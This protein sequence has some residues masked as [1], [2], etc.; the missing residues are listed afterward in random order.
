MGPKQLAG[1]MSIV[2]R[3]AAERAGRAFDEEADAVARQAIE[4]Q[5]DGRV[6]RP[7]RHRSPLGRRHHRSARHAHRRSASRC[8]PCTAGRSRAPSPSACSDCDRSDHDRS[9]RSA[10]CSSPTGVRS[11]SGC[12][13]PPTSSVCAP[14]PSTPNRTAPQPM[15]TWPTWPCPSADRRRPTPISTRPSCS[16]PPSAQGADAVHPGYGFLSENADFA[17]AVVDAGLTWVG[18]H[19]EAIAVDGRQAGGQAAGRRRRHPHPAQRRVDRRRRARAGRVQADDVGYPLLIKAAAGRRRAG[20]AAR[21]RRGRA[22]RG[23]ALGPPRSGGLLRPP[24]RVRRALAGRRPD[25]VEVQVVADQLGNAIHLGERECSIQRRHQ[26]LIEECPSPAVDD[27]LRESLGAAALDAGPGHRLRQRRHR[28]VP[29]RSRERRQFYFLEMNTRIQVEHRVTEEVVGCDLVWWQ[30]QCARGEP[31][32]WIQDDVDLTDHP[33][34]RGP[35]LRRGPGS[36]LAARH[37]HDPPVRGSARPHF[38][39]DYVMV[40]SGMAVNVDGP[41]PVEV[42]PALRPAAGQVHRPR[43]HRETAIGRLVRYLI[44]LELHGVT[45]NRDYLLAVLQHPDFLDGRTTTLFVADHP[46]LLDAGPDADTVARHAAR[47]LVWRDT[48]AATTRTVLALRP[49]RAGATSGRPGWI[50]G[51]ATGTATSTSPAPGSS[52][53]RFAAE[54]DGVSVEGRLLERRPDH[55][56]LEIDGAT[57]CYWVS[58]SRSTPPMSTRALG[59]DR[60]GRAPDRFGEPASAGDRRRARRPRARPGRGRRGGGGR[61]GLGGPDTGRARVR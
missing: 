55:V 13:M 18:P 3:S 47:H 45:T 33:R 52:D 60:P 34:H 37:R 35:A 58:P 7:V 17:Q 46:V 31:L 32:E 5:I 44:E 53:E 6:D 1:V 28:R 2:Q 4:A 24:D 25:H 36:G 39:D 56:L 11:P 20:H 43:P 14:S 30:I 9:G 16:T 42:T 21:G 19:P 59:P 41:G 54:V 12:S 40:D 26:K 49:A 61:H 23:G 38:H 50:S 22:G 10:R 57:R 8:R 48:E 15:S 51:S 29:A 27:V